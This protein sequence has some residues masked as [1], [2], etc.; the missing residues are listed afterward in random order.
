[1]TS[2]CRVSILQNPTPIPEQN[3]PVIVNTKNYFLNYLWQEDMSTKNLGYQV[4][5]NEILILHVHCVIINLIY[6]F[7]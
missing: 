4:E 6:L 1:M 5:D 3:A 7:M 2:N